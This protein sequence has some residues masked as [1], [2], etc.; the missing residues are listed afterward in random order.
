MLPNTSEFS[1]NS[2]SQIEFG[3]LQIKISNLSEVIEECSLDRFKM[4]EWIWPKYVN[5]TKK[6]T[7]MNLNNGE[8]DRKI[9]FFRSC[10]MVTF[11]IVNFSVMSQIWYVTVTR[12]NDVSNIGH[13]MPPTFEKKYNWGWVN[14]VT[15]ARPGRNPANPRRWHFSN[16]LL[17]GRA[18]EVFFSS[19]LAGSP[20]GWGK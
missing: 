14:Y 9:F 19:S 4:T 20:S 16:Q 5:M 8:H 11:V 1:Q 7:T 3:H 17:P 15:R 18:E 2:R 6:F 13:K 12:R 10:S